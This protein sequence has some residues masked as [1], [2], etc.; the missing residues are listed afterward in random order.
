MPPPSPRLRW[1]WLGPLIGLAAP[2]AALRLD[3]GV[4]RDF[5]ERRTLDPARLDGRL[6]AAEPADIYVIGNS[7]AHNAVDEVVLAEAI[8]RS[9]DA[10]PLLGAPLCGTAMLGPDLAERRPTAVVLVVSRPDLDRRCATDRVRR[11]HPAVAASIFGPGDLGFH[12]DGAA[13]WSSL[14]VRHRH[15]LREWLFGDP[16]TSEWPRDHRTVIRAARWPRLFARRRGQH[17][18]A[19][20]DGTGPNASG[21]VD[22]ALRLRAAGATLYVVQAPHHPKLFGGT[23]HA[24]VESVLAMLARRHGFVHVPAATLGAYPASAFRDPTHLGA[25]GRDR[26][27]AVLAG[28]LRRGLGHATGGAVPVNAR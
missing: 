23:T 5:A 14:F 6:R 9:V 28:V 19:V 13:A 16:P 17:R 7:I 20:V 4:W 10:L 21:L 2:E 11:W 3:D 24:D 27:T 1:L 22:L 12:L 25:Q 15:R 26:F 18:A 8:G